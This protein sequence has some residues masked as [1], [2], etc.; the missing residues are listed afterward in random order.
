MRVLLLPG[1]P[2]HEFARITASTP[3]VVLATVTT[4]VVA[5]VMQPQLLREVWRV[6]W[7]APRGAS[8]ASV[9][10]VRPLRATESYRGRACCTS[11]AL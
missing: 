9:F 6:A 10:A 8:V 11:F 2:P 7:R 5:I 4:T 3:L 1:A